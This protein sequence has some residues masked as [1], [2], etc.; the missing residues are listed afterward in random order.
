MRSDGVRS[1]DGRLCGLAL[2]YVAPTWLRSRSWLGMVVSR[3]THMQHGLRGSS[4][5]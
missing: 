4:H 2:Y 1:V 3:S 5:W